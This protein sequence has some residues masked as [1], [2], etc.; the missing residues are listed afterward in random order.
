[1]YDRILLATDGSIASENADAHAID[2]AAAHD[3]TLHV[4]FVLD[5]GVYTAY[6]GDEYV[7]E[8]EGPEHGLEE[9]GRAVLDEVARRTE[10]RGVEVVTAM[11]RGQPHETIVDYAAEADADLVV[12]GTRRRPAEYRNLLGSVTDRVLRLT[13]RP[14]L[15]IKTDAGG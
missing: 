1:M 3:A 9:R 8:A 6:S 13:D 5:E 7:D 14:A 2:L 11:E 4:L 10:G 15:V 12:L